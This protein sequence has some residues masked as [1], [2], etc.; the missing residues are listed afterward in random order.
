MSETGGNFESQ[1]DGVEKATREEVEALLADLE[2]YD[3]QHSRGAWLGRG[4]AGLIMSHFEGQDDEDEEK[5][6]E[7]LGESKPSGLEHLHEEISKNLKLQDLLDR[8]QKTLEKLGIDLESPNPHGDFDEQETYAVGD[9]KID[10]TNQENFVNYLKSIDEKSLSSAELKLVKMVIEKVLNRVRQ[11]YNFESADD[12][13]L[14]L[15]S[16][17][18]DM[19]AESKRLGL[20]KEAEELERCIHYNKQKALPQYIHARNRRFLEPIGEGF[21]WSTYQRDCTPEKYTERWEEAFEALDEAKESKNSI[22]LY[23][24]ILSYATACIEFAEKDI[25]GPERYKNYSAG[26]VEKITPAIEKTKKKL[27]KYK[28]LE[29]K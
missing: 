26:Y 18:K 12:R 9:M 19:V 23:N 20:E 25:A 5:D 21:S 28:P 17:I 15:F 2:T 16:G 14:E 11:E 6:E 22:Q 4:M 8:H 27:S 1:E 29:S 24:D 10:F 7:T 13:L 3:D